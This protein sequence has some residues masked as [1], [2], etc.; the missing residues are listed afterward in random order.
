[1]V[2]FPGM[3][4]CSEG[5][6]ETRLQAFFKMLCASSHLRVYRLENE[7]KEKKLQEEDKRDPDSF[8]LTF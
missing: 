2:N 8:D 7:A 6:G 3:R 5:H 4:L 1:M